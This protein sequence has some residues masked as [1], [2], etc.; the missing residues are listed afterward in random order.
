MSYFIVDLIFWMKTE[1]E[2]FW[3][4]VMQS[5]DLMLDLSSFLIASTQDSTDNLSNKMP[6][7]P[8][9][10]VSVTPPLA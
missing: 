10:T 9:I 1:G 4:W 7:V 2:N 5:T 3:A 6:V 8:S